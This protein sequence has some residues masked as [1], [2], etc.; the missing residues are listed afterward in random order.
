MFLKY[1]VDAFFICLFSFALS[2]SPS[3]SLLLLCV[4][5][6]RAHFSSCLAKKWQKEFECRA[7]RALRTR[8]RSIL[9]LLL[10]ICRCAVGFSPLRFHFGLLFMC[11]CVRLCCRWFSLLRS[12][13]VCACL[14]SLGS[15][16]FNFINWKCKK[17]K[18]AR[19]WNERVTLECCVYVCVSLSVSRVYVALTLNVSSSS[20]IFG[21][22]QHIQFNIWALAHTH[23]HCT[24]EV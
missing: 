20:T 2:L 24:T 17:D 16:S 22:I 4:C 6:L 21:A 14:V 5:L 7:R 10:L 13:C 12:F 1:A 3:H 23:T 18:T 19:E 11:A 9:L 15:C 8:G